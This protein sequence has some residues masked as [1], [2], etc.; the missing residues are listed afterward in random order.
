M[1]KEK[2]KQILII[3]GLFIIILIS[4]GI[5]YYFNQK[6]EE[7]FLL[8]EDSKITNNIT[9]EITNEE[10]NYKEEENSIIVH[11]TGEVVNPGIVKLK[12][13]ARV[14]DAIEKAG[15]KTEMADISKVNLAYILE[16]GSKIYIPSVEDK[17]DIAQSETNQ[18]KKVLRVNINTAKQTELQQLPGIG[19]AMAKR[20]VDYRKENGKFSSVEEL[21]KVSGIGDSK[22]KDLKEYVY[23]K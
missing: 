21:K 3:C 1:L 14:Y 4:V 22:F 9:N 6:N 10:V 5:Y 19:E 20:I 2:Y 15:G 17:E 8:F 23:V 7:D 12:E 13:N 11:I 16:D 18:E